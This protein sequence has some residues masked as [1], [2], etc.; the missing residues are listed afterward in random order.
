VDTRI[1]I[2]AARKYW[3][4]LEPF[5]R[6]FYINDLARE[7]SSKDINENFR[8]NYQ[9]LVAIKKTYDPTNLFRMNANIQPPAG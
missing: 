3:T 8:G 4:A 6:G 5:T 7:A 1:H 9:R 2:Q